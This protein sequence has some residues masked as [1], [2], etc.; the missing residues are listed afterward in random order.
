[1]RFLAEAPWYPTALLPSQGVRWEPVS[2]TSAMAT[3]T[4]GNAVVSLRFEFNEMGLIDSV[5][6]DARWRTVKEE[7]IP[8][9]WTG[10]FWKYEIRDGMQ[11]PM[12][13]EVA[14]LLPEGRKPY[15][16]GCISGVNYEFEE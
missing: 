5:H 3:I 7:V 4:D 9:P 13:A 6:A 1:M 8:T 15:W 10:R 14:W 11:V 16:R 2:D 12:E